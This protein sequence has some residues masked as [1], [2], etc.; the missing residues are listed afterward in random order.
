[1]KSDNDMDCVFGKRHK[2]RKRTKSENESEE[3]EPQEQQK[4]NYHFGNFTNNSFCSKNWS[5]WRNPKIVNFLAN[6][7]VIV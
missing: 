6:L 3:K 4:V 7:F 5:S 1:M 2:K